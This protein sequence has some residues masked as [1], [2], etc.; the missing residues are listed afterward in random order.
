MF[1]HWAIFYFFIGVRIAPKHH[2]LLHNIQNEKQNKRSYF[3]FPQFPLK[4]M[5]SSKLHKNVTH[6]NFFSS[7][8]DI[9]EPRARSTLSPIYDTTFL[10][11]SISPV[12]REIAPPQK[13]LLPLFSQKL[14]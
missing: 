2:F 8:F 10:F 3:W 9:I 7:K 1:Y 6:W 12:E 5:T 11:V 13:N 14:L 4:L